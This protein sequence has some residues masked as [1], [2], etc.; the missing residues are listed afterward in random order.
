MSC[1]IGCWPPLRAT[2]DP[3]PLYRALR[4]MGPIHR[5]GLDGVWYTT[6]LVA[7]RRVLLDPCFGKGPRLTIRRHGVPEE[8]VKMVEGRPLRPTMITANPPEHSRL[9]GAAKGAFLPARMEALRDRIATLVDPA[10][11]SAGRRRDGRRHDRARLHPA[12]DGH[13]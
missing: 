4:T 6:P 8:R 12:P 11:R 7:A 3:Y 1:S 5:C 2:P 10:P 13:R 9:R